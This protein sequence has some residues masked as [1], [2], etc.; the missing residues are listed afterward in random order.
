MIRLRASNGRAL[1]VPDPSLSALRKRAQKFRGYR[2]EGDAKR[3]HWE[4][5]IHHLDNDPAN[6]AP[7]NRKTLCRWCHLKAHGKKTR[8]QMGWRHRRDAA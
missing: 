2:C 8:K 5:H 6:N 7:A 1:P 4:L 3:H